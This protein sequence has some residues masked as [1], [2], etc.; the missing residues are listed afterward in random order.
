M[1]RRHCS[2]RV[3]RALP[4]PSQRPRPRHGTTKRCRT[5]CCF[6]SSADCRCASWAWCV[7]CAASGRRPARRIAYGNPSLSA[8]GEVSASATSNAHQQLALNISRVAR[9]RRR[10]TGL[11][12]TRRIALIRTA[13]SRAQCC[14]YR[15]MDPLLHLHAP[16]LHPQHPKHRIRAHQA[17]HH[18][19]TFFLRSC[20]Q[21]LGQTLHPRPRHLPTVPQHLPL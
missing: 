17:S 6:I 3:R 15:L 21:I 12:T 9:A 19:L 2:N 13:R 5:S 20:H 18:R 14:R 16:R 4:R 1:V 7:S 11:A 8:C 10:R